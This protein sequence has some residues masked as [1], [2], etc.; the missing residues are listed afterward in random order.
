V[1]TRF[2]RAR[3]AMQR[4]LA[5]RTGAASAMAFTFGQARCDRVVAAVL[6]RLKS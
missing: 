4:D 6:A 5:Q 3:R 1:K 2:S